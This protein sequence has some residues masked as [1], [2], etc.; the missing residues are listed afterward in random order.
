VENYNGFA[1]RFFWVLV[2]RTNFIAVP[3]ILGPSDFR[4]EI[5]YFRQ[6]DADG[7]TLLERIAGIRHMN[8]SPEAQA[9]Y[10]QI[11][12]PL[13]IAQEET[14]QLD[15]ILRR[16]APTPKNDR[17]FQA[18]VRCGSPVVRLNWDSHQVPTV[19]NF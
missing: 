9:Y 15:A 5:E 2:R 14:P 19:P 4:E 16:A 11:Y 18:R 8:W 7:K 1:N 3:P 17:S 12:P 13:D 10:E 6:K